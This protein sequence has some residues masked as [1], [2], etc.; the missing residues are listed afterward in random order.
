VILRGLFCVFAKGIGGVRRGDRSKEPLGERAAISPLPGD[1]SG[2]K[3]AGSPPYRN[4]Q[5]VE[6][7]AV[8]GTKTSRLLGVICQP[9]SL[10]ACGETAS[11]E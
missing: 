6:M 10:A 7:V 9:W 2:G 3:H 11:R 1:T 5:G 4:S 8:G